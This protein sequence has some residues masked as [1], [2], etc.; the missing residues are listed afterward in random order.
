MKTVLHNAIE[1]RSQACFQTIQLPRG[2]NTGSRNHHL[3][4]RM[5]SHN[6][7]GRFLANLRTITMADEHPVPTPVPSPAIGWKRFLDLGCIV[8][9]LPFLLPLMALIALWIKLVS[10][11]P[12]LLRQRRIG[13]DGGSFVLYKFRG[14]K[15][16]TDTT[17]YASYVR[18]LVQSNKPMTKLD[19][20]CNSHLIAGGRWLRS[21]GLDELPQL[22][23]VLCGEMT[24]V[25]PRPCLPGEYALFSPRQRERF[26]AVPG[27]TGLWQVSGKN[28]SSFREMNVMDIYY[29]RHTSMVLDI[30]IILRTPV[31]LLRQMLL[32]FQCGRRNIHWLNMHVSGNL[33]HRCAAHD[34]HRL[35]Q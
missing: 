24:L 22:W 18:H 35:W 27:M 17:H 30:Y 12:V 29:S 16:N 25:G 1:K 11:G 3:I 19:F 31:A 28:Q 6:P 2:V 21:S 5:T 32:S 8:I 13:K 14:I 4:S 10:G 9:S 15:I 20:I 33:S 34:R 26:K 23:N 7:N